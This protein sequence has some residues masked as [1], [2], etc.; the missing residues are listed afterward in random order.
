MAQIAALSAIASMFKIEAD[1]KMVADAVLNYWD[2]QPQFAIIVNTSGLD[3]KFK[4][5]WYEV[6]FLLSKN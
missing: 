2:S 4:C 3:Q 5:N 6:G 1:P